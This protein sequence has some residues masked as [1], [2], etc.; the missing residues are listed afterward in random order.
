MPSAPIP[1]IVVTLPIATPR[2]FKERE[3]L[4]AEFAASRPQVAGELL[5]AD[6]MDRVILRRF[7]GQLHQG[8][9]PLDRLGT[10]SE[11]HVR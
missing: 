11:V 7:G 6:P 9:T 1:K 3:T 5:G 4:H 8:R 2:A 10:R